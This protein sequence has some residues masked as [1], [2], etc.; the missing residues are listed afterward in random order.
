MSRKGVDQ[1]TF[2][3][4]NGKISHVYVLIKFYK[5]TTILTKVANLKSLWLVKVI[6]A[7]GFLFYLWYL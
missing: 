7:N 2:S 4:V 6:K 1:E 3:Q 5:L